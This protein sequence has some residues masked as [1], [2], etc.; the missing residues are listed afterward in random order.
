MIDIAKTNFLSSLEVDKIL[1]TYTGSFTSTQ[2]SAT[3]PAKTTVTE[4]ITTNIADTTFFQG[5]FSIDGGTTWNDFGYNKFPLQV[6]GL[7]QSGTFKIIAINS[8]SFINPGSDSAYT[9]SYKVA[10]IAKPSQGTISPQPIGSIS[11]FKSSLNY[12]KILSDTSQNASVASGS[13][14]TLTFNHTLGAIPKVRSFIEGS[15][16]GFGTGMY[17]LCTMDNY[18]IG[19]IN[20]TEST[21]SVLVN[22]DNTPYA[23]TIAGAVYMRIYY[24]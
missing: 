7:S 15:N 20:V 9:V 18:G 10:L 4:S 14:G 12:Q 2:P 3:P 11:F 19:C 13:T 8:H 22:I 1:G 23:G 17:E 5:I 6:F 24:D 21:S 16:P